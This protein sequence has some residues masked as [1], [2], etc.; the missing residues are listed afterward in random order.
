MR[1]ERRV[2]FSIPGGRL[3]ELG[4]HGRH[5]AYEMVVD[6]ICEVATKT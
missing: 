5:E 6:L 2:G 3:K 1:K 4:M